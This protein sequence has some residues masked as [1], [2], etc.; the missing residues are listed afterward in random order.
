MRVRGS[1]TP[2]ARPT[3]PTL[4]HTLALAYRAGGYGVFSRYLYESGRRRGRLHHRADLDLVLVV[5]PDRTAKPGGIAR[6]TMAMVLTPAPGE[7]P[8]GG[9]RCQSRRLWDHLVF[10]AALNVLTGKAPQIHKGY[11][12]EEAPLSLE[13]CAF[14]QSLLRVRVH[15]A[16]FRRSSALSS[17]GDQGRMHINGP[18][19]CELWQPYS[20]SY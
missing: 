13:F 4:Y 6:S 5:K 17:G 10:L 8:L 12:A 20:Y 18:A 14:F 3:L 7:S 1:G 19:R 9:I 16:T 11:V 15:G 2:A